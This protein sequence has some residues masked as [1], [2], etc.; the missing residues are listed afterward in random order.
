MAIVLQAD[1]Q[2]ALDMFIDALW[3]EEGLAK[4]TLDSYRLDI[5]QFATWLEREHQADYCK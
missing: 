3:L 5:S 1:N 2:Q 4:N